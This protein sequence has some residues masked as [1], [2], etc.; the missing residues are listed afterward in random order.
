MNFEQNEN[1]GMIAQMVRDF[2][3]K[4]IKPNMK[5]WDDHEVFPVETMKK[6][7]RARAP[8][9]FYTRR[10]W[11]FWFWLCGICDRINGAW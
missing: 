1:Q 3:E 11:W 7:W 9:Y 6:T 4:E 2:A 5:S 10:I 8:R